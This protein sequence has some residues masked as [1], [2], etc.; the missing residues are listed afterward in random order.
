MNLI[1]SP[2]VI[3]LSCPLFSA[4]SDRG[5]ALVLCPTHCLLLHLELTKGD[6]R[7]GFASRRT[8]NTGA[9]DLNGSRQAAAPVGIMSVD[10]CRIGINYIYGATLSK[11]VLIWSLLGPVF[12]PV[13]AEP[14]TGQTDGGGGG[15]G[16]PGP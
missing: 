6:H 5:K 4:S 3:L 1:E 12:R 2:A 9:W 16:W 7:E 15:G 10:K 13:S 8:E 14:T 11:G